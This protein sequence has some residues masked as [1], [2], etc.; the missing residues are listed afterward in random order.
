[1][2][3]ML[4]AA[5]GRGFMAISRSPTTAAASRSR[6]ASR[7]LARRIEEID[8]LNAGLSDFV[9]PKLIEVDILENRSLDLVVGAPSIPSIWNG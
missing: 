1:M 9:V 4:Q 6:T 5:R 2:L 8:R 3:K 7:R